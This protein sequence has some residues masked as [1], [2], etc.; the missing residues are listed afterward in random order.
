MGLGQML[1]S[2]LAM[3]LLGGVLLMMNNTTLDSGSAVET[4]EY[5]IMASSLGVSQMEQ[6]LGKAFDENTVSSDVGSTASL[7][8]TLTKEGAE[9]EAT[10]DDFDD[11]NGFS[12]TVVGDSVFFRS[13][14]Y[15]I[16]DSVDYVTISGNA[17]V[18]SA[19]R[20]YHK[21]LRVWV[22]SPFMKDTLKFQTVY[23]YWYFR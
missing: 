15:L 5:V 6:A 1:L 9:V 3:S 14:T 10:F 22:S 20:T 13:A 23:S 18:T 4:T 17:V 2:V 12:K 19:S 11:Y 7:S 16:S 21:R 8:S